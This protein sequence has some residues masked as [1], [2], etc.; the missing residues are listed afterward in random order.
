MNLGALS[1]RTPGQKAKHCKDFF[2]YSVRGL[3][4]H[5]IRRCL[6]KGPVTFLKGEIMTRCGSK[7]GQFHSPLSPVASRSSLTRNHQRE[8]RHRLKAQLPSALLWMG[9]TYPSFS[10]GQ[11][12]FPRETLTPGVSRSA[13]PVAFF[14]A[15]PTN[16]TPPSYAPRS[17]NSG[18]GLGAGDPS[19]AQV[20]LPSANPDRVPE[21]RW[22]PMRRRW[23]VGENCGA[24]GAGPPDLLLGSLFP[25]PRAPRAPTGCGPA[26]FPAPRLSD[27]P[28]LGEWQTFPGGRGPR[29]AD[30]RKEGA[31]G[32]AVSSGAPASPSCDAA[33]AASPLAS[34][35]RA[36]RG[37][38]ETGTR[39]GGGAGPRGRGLG[40]ASGLA[41][42]RVG[43]GGGAGP[44][45]GG[46]SVS[47][48]ARD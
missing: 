43:D 6:L 37:G 7:E 33:A 44:D 16:V 26:M 4:F 13:P 32:D 1:Q 17:P 23:G 19:M 8:L 29:E 10:P 22:A 3:S 24:R 47:G 9:R 12:S 21:Q 20:R 46:A 48:R 14:Y 31:L 18:G 42:A 38:R 41:W 39:A 40:G 45:R 25:K 2:L 5:E 11:V 15:L 30:K 34:S 27:T 36:A 28:A 35:G